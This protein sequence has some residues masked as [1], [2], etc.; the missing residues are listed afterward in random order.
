MS[1]VKRQYYDHDSRT[2]TIVVNGF[3]SKMRNWS[4][5]RNI[6]SRPFKV[7]GN[8]FTIDIF[9]NSEDNYVGIFL[10]N[11]DENIVNIKGRMMMGEKLAEFQTGPVNPKC[12][13][14]TSNFYPHLLLHI[15]RSPFLRNDEY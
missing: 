2:Y 7:D 8:K 14:G 3:A 13:F 15:N 4:R 5:E 10:N 12:A 9:P 11:E 1:I 6:Y